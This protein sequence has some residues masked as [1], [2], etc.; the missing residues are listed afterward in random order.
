MGSRGHNDSS[1]LHVDFGNENVLVQYNFFY[2][3]EGYGTEILG[4]N[5]NVIWRY[6]V[7]VGD[8]TRIPR[9]DRPGD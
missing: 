7:S 9:I 3:N 8:A 2:D 4:K 6:N 1:G 5:N